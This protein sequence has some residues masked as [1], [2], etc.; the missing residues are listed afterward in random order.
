MTELKERVKGAWPQA[1]GHGGDKRKAEKD[2]E[3]TKP[4]RLEE[5]EKREEL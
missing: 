2:P 5:N 1:L 3:K 4:M